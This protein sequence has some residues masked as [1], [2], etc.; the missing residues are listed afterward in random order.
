M[1]FHAFLLKFAGSEYH[2]CG[3]STCTVATLALGEKSMLEM[4]QQAV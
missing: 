4:V 1:L 2:V 3:S